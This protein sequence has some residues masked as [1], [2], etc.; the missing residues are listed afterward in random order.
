V[1]GLMVLPA[2]VLTHRKWTFAYIL[3]QFFVN[4]SEIKKKLKLTQK[5]SRTA[6]NASKFNQNLK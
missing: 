1:I 4:I 3:T 5:R 2:L 6:Q